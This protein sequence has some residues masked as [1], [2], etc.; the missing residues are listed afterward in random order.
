MYSKN[1]KKLIETFGRAALPPFDKIFPW[2]FSRHVNHNEDH[3]LG[4]FV[5][6][7]FRV[8]SVDW[9]TFE[10]CSQHLEE[11]PKECIFRFFKDFLWLWASC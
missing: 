1:K 2:F 9:R 7:F 10:P 8:L 5:F 11:T 4:G 3:P 6:F